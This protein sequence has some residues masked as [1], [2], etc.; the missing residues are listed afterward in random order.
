MKKKPDI[1]RAYFEKYNE[2]NN[3]NPLLKSAQA[4]HPFID[5]SNWASPTRR[6]QLGVPIKNAIHVAVHAYAGAVAWWCT[7]KGHRTVGIYGILN[8]LVCT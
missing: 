2:I 5:N 4:K 8:Q 6:L 7:G 1:C 3:Y